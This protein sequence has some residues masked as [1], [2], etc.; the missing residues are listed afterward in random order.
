MNIRTRF[1][2]DRAFRDREAAKKDRKLRRRYETGKRLETESWLP[3]PVVTDGV[4]ELL[5]PLA[6]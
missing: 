2:T 6:R 1:D 4:N 5:G 3:N